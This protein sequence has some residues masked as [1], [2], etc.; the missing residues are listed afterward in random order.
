MKSV[1]STQPYHS[2]VHYLIAF[3]IFGKLLYYLV[4]SLVDELSFG[5]YWIN[6]ENLLKKSSMIEKKNS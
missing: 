6:K 1:K 4:D 2:F 3:N 5:N